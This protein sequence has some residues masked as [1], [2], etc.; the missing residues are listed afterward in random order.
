LNKAEGR[1]QNHHGKRGEI[2]ERKRFLE[3]C[4]KNAV[5]PKSVFVSAD[6][7]KYHPLEYRLCFDK[8]GS[9]VHRVVLLD[10]KENSIINCSLDLVKEDESERK[11]G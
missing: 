9:V 11:E 1:R 6:G 5:Y 3:L 4:Q 8:N 10:I 2:M 7:I